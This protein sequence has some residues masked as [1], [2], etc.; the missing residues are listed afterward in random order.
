MLCPKCKEEI[1]FLLIDETKVCT[2]EVS[3]QDG[4]LHYEEL[5]QGQDV[6][7]TLADDWRCHNCGEV[8]AH[9]SEEAVK[10]LKEPMPTH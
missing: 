6:G 10:L 9:S 5:W 2:Y 3:L 1:N 8:I 7:G 4:E